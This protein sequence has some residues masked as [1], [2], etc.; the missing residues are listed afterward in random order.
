LNPSEE[1]KEQYVLLEGWYLF[2]SL[3]GVTRKKK[4]VFVQKFLSFLRDVLQ[5][6]CIIPWPN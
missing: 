5:P 2:T 4:V 3:F 6:K 1:Q